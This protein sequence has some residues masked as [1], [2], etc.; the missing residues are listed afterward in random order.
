MSIQ[1][2]YQQLE[3]SLALGNSAAIVSAYHANGGVD[4][5][6]LTIDDEQAWARLK[7]LEADPATQTEGPVAHRFEKDGTLALVEHYNSKPRFI[8]LGAGHI[9]LALAPIAKAA[10]FEV[11]V[12]DDRAS[13][14]NRQNFPDVDEI[15]CDGFDQVFT[16]IPLRASDYVVIVTRGH[17]HD[18]DCLRGILAGVEP[19]YTGMI[20]SKRRVAIVREQLCAEGYDA[21]R[22]ERTH[23]PIGLRIGAV[24]PFEIAV[25]ILAEV[26]EVKR[27]ERAEARYSTCDP[28]IAAEL[29]R[30][31]DDFDAM[32]TIF[33]T[34]GS[35]PIECGAKLAM[36]YAGVIAGTIGGGCSEGEAMTVA[37]E[38]IN[39]ETHTDTT[40]SSTAPS[41]SDASEGKTS[42]RIH[43]VDMSDSA[44]ED[45]MVCGGTMRVVVEEM[46]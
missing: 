26:I 5:R 10:D 3:Q 41:R 7:E 45:G 36:T 20:G 28:A 6:L 33:S 44:E 4:K 25:A 19:A 17:K 30:R 37:R 43:T 2:L 39:S 8:I 11:L 15:I 24:T 31:G 27:I 13:F 14:A 46:L 21:A 12:Y 34:Q 1:T 18:A 9:A 22:I 32:I 40:G 42:W 16:R 35:V 23:S 38:L 29:A